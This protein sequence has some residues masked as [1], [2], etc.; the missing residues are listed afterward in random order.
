MQDLESHI[1]LSADNAVLLEAE[2]IE[3]EEYVDSL[4]NVIRSV[5]SASDDDIRQ[6]PFPENILSTILANK[7]L[8]ETRFREEKD[9]V[10]MFSTLA[11]YIA[12]QKEGLPDHS[13]VYMD[14]VSAIRKRLNAYYGADTQKFCGS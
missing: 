11:V 2:K 14:R 3:A 10:S 9:R 6:L 8:I 13:R 5:E 12:C 7:V 1:T 4:R